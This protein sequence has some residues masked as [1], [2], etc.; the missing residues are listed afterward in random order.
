MSCAAYSEAT[1]VIGGRRFG[2]SSV[3]LETH[4]QACGQ[5]PPLRFEVAAH[6][7]LTDQG[8]ELLIGLA[9]ALAEQGNRYLRE[10]ALRWFR[11][12]A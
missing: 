11:R 1:L 4:E 5:A 6:I 7:E 8:R 12:V 9:E 10:T 3:V 2:V